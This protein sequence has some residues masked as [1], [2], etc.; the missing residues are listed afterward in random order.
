VAGGDPW[1]LLRLILRLILRLFRG[2]SRGCF[3]RGAGD[4]QMRLGWLVMRLAAAD[5]VAVLINP[6]SKNLH[7]VLVYLI[8]NF[9]NYVV[10]TY[11]I[12]A[13]TNLYIDSVR[14]KLTT[15]CETRA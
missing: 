14:V 1:L 5:P 7:G 9:I 8:G 10:I 15:K 6:P 4:A 2:C 11:I 3:L 12:L 13:V